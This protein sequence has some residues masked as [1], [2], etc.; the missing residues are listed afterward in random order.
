MFK[1]I[2]ASCCVA[3]FM[4]GCASGIKLS[5]YKE[6]DCDKKEC[7]VQPPDY[8]LNKKKPKVAILQMADVTEY[9]GKLSE[10]GT[11]SLTQSIT[12]GTGLEV[13][14]R[15]QVKRLFEEYKFKSELSG[16]VDPSAFSKL[17]KDVDF[18]I[19]GSIP[20]AS[21]GAKFSEA[22][23][24]T[25]KKGKSHY[26]APSCTVSAE[27]VVNVRAVSTTNGTI[28]KVF[29]PFK[30]RVSGSSEVR[31]SSECRVKDPLQLVLQ[32]V[33]NS[34]EKAKDSFI[35]A[36]PNFGY[37]AKTMT[38]PQNQKDR[39]AVITLG[40]NDGL[41]AGDKVVLAKYVK[42]Y[43]RIKKSNSLSI[44]DVGEVK[45]SETGLADEQSYV[46]IPEEVADDVTVGY[47]VKT[48]ADRSLFKKFG[49]LLK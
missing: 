29:E 49:N 43:D 13:V 45:I 44:Q 30:G 46:Q 41:K 18:V 12:G 22:S 20:T 36:F 25:D 15:S 2:V 33:N 17:V 4:S 9:Q 34:I 7:E 16:E 28:Y 21:V 27:A 23:S 19:L 38:N 24:Y 48:K 32:A 5:N 26:I 8:I 40:R 10:P 47:I 14:E 3:L 1:K 35:D 6:L 37:A 42:S 39:I 11:E 31:S